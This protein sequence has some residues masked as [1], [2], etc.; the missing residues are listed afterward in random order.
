MSEEQRQRS[1]ASPPK[2]SGAVLNDGSM[3]GTWSFEPGSATRMV[4]HHVLPLT[5]GAAAAV[6][7][8]GRRALAFLDP[9]ATE[10]EVRFE[11]L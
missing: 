4:V 3:F 10:G 7:A 5:T 11:A 6:E 2:I 1:Y 8:E 9:D